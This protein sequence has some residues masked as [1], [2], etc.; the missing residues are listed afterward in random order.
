MELISA[1]II[2]IKSAKGIFNV[3]QL[4]LDVGK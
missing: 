1:S 4:E 3:Q 2:G